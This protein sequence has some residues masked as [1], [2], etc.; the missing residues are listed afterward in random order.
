MATVPVRFEFYCEGGTEQLTFVH[1]IPQE[2]VRR[3]HLMRENG[4]YDDRFMAAVTPILKARAKACQDASSI[5]CENCGSKATDIL[6]HVL[7]WLNKVEDP[8]IGVY[9]C[10]VC[11]RGECETMLRQELGAVMNEIEPDCVGRRQG[12][13]DVRDALSLDTATKITKGKTGRRT[14][15]FAGIQILGQRQLV[16]ERSYGGMAVQEEDGERRI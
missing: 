15:R 5:S 10:A 11:G 12:L 16:L 2:L 6:Q 13:S 14:R 4:A 7:S 3:S 9:V 1:D 8:F